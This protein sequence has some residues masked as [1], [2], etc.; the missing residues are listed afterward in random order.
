[1]LMCQ[2]LFFFTFKKIKRKA[3]GSARSLL[4]PAARPL[5]MMNMQTADRRI[6]SLHPARRAHI[7]GKK[8]SEEAKRAGGRRK[9][10]GDSTLCN[11]QQ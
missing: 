10:A 5:A 2:C 1:M 4:K 11:Y 7:G 9:T 6:S 3:G 8:V